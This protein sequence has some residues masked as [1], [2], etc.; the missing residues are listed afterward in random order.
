MRVPVAGDVDVVD[1]GDSGGDGGGVD[2]GEGGGVDVGNGGGVDVGCSVG[3]GN[4]CEGDGNVDSG[5]GVV[6]GELMVRRVLDFLFRSLCTDSSE[7]DM[8]EMP[9]S[10]HV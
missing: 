5:G 1:C 10:S 2:V 6:D 8:G 4:A 3:G 9:I 7:S